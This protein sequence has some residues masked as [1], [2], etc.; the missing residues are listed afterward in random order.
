MAAKSSRGQLAACVAQRTKFPASARWVACALVSQVVEVALAGGGQGQAAGGEP[1][2]QGDGGPDVPLGGDDLAVG[3]V[4]AAE[5][6]AA[7][8]AATC[9]T[10]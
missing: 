8:G 10:A 3:G 5:A 9:Q 4:R 6:A 7:A 1:V 2:E